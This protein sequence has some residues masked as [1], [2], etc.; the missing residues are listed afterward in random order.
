MVC[1]A[2]R[3]TAVGRLQAD[4]RRWRN[5]V[6]VRKSGNKKVHLCLKEMEIFF[7]PEVLHSFQACEEADF[8]VVLLL[9]G[10]IL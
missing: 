9:M 4:E 8:S 2:E 3:P 7:C 1:A 6:Q 5:S 10:Q